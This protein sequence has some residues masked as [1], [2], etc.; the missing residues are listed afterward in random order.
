[1]V[2]VYNIPRKVIPSKNMNKNL[3]FLKIEVSF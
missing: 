2:T 1:M 3:I